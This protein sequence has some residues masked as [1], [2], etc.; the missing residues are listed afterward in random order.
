MWHFKST[1]WESLQTLIWKAISMKYSWLKFIKLNSSLIGQWAFNQSNDCK[2][3]TNQVNSAAEVSKGLNTIKWNILSPEQTWN[4][5]KKSHWLF[6]EVVL[7]A[8]WKCLS[9]HPEANLYSHFVALESPPDSSGRSPGLTPGSSGARSP[10]G[11]ANKGPKGP[12]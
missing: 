10:S 6:C 11:G 7:K 2:S 8:A 4:F 3:P 1:F 9:W 12:F 5:A